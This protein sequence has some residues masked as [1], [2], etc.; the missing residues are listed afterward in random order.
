MTHTYSTRVRIRSDG[1]SS[2]KIGAELVV[3]DVVRSLYLTIRGSGILLFE[4]LQ[5]ERDRDELVAAL[6]ASFEVDTDT[7]RRDIDA[8]IAD[9]SN[10]GL[11]SD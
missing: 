6:L 5:E 9:L 2:R 4:L 3:L 11:I 7:A 10:A 8:F 1:L